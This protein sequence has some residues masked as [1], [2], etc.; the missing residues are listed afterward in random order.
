MK[1]YSSIKKEGQTEHCGHTT[2]KGLKLAIRRKSLKEGTFKCT[3]PCG[4][5]HTWVITTKEVTSKG[6]LKGKIKVGK[7][8]S[9]I[10]T[11]AK[12]IACTKIS[13]NTSFQKLIY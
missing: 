3:T 7:G 11:T 10:N 2:I 4:N 1:K 5:I 9:I 12:L 13:N 8:S 6:R